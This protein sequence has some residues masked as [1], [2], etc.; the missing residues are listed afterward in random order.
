MYAFV[1]IRHFCSIS[2][3]FSCWGASPRSSEALSSDPS[4]CWDTWIGILYRSMRPPHR[5]ALRPLCFAPKATNT[6]ILPQKPAE[7]KRHLGLPGQ[8]LEGNQIRPSPR[9]LT[10]G[11]ILVPRIKV[12]QPWVA[13]LFC[14]RFM[15]KDYFHPCIGSLVSN[16]N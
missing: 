2:F 4:D 11:Q 1:L 9:L 7:S 3:A 13:T 14:A 12:G 10:A 16:S 8:T 5:S 15:D 6:V